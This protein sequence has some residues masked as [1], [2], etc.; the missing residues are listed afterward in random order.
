[1]LKSWQVHP[2]HKL[3]IQ[4]Q[5]A[6]PLEW[7]FFTISRKQIS[8]LQQINI[9]ALNLQSSINQK[10]SIMLSTIPLFCQTDNEILQFPEENK[11]IVGRH[12]FLYRCYGVILLTFTVFLTAVITLLFGLVW[13]LL[14]F[15]LNR[16]MNKY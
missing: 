7:L 12:R 5:K 10:N 15:N 9:L 2:T 4:I 11:P 1:M 14:I 8:I 6:V 3:L 16:F 13:S